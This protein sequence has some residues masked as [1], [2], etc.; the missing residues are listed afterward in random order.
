MWV[1]RDEKVSTRGK[2]RQYACAEIGDL[3]FEALKWS[4]RKVGVRPAYGDERNVGGYLEIEG[5]ECP[6]NHPS[7]IPY[8]RIDTRPIPTK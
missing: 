5:V 1:R 3:F 6:R 4:V 8:W 7:A 2:A